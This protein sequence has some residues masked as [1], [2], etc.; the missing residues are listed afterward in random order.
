MQK[1]I[2]IFFYFHKKTCCGSSLEAP[3][4]GASNEYQHVFMP[5]YE[6]YL[7]DTLFYPDILYTV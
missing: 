3:S 6:K 4:L 5:K 7:S 2:D 1:S